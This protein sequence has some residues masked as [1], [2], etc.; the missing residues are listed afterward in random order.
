MK[1]KPN[2][3]H[4]PG[5]WQWTAI[6]GGWDGVKQEN[7]TLICKLALNEPENARLIAAAPDLLDACLETLTEIR[8]YQGEDEF[9]EGPTKDACDI[10]KSAITKATGETP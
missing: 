2:S 10:L 9:C 4:T 7:G 1:T 6:E 3:R 8:A 5:P